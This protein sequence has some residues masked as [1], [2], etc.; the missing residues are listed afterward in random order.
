MDAPDPF[1]AEKSTE[2][3]EAR[4]R[5]L[6]VVFVVMSV[7]FTSVS[8]VKMSC[9][10]GSGL[11]GA[12]GGRPRGVRAGLGYSAVTAQQPCISC[13]VSLPSYLIVRTAPFTPALPFDRFCDGTWAFCRRHDGTHPVERRL[14]AAFDR[15][16]ALIDAEIAFVGLRFGRRAAAVAVEGAAFAFLFCCG[17]EDARGLRGSVLQA[18]SRRRSCDIR[19]RILSVSPNSVAPCSPSRSCLF[20]ASRCRHR[21]FCRCRRGLAAAST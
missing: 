2:Q 12:S 13:S 6:G 21:R 18:G 10:G 1:D 7:V 19:S 5:G 4:R 9:I 3:G 16:V 14:Y 11:P 20:R 8:S 15:R 17:Y